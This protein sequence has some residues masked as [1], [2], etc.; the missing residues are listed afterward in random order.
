MTTTAEQCITATGLNAYRQERS[1]HD[2]IILSLPASVYAPQIGGG[3]SYVK[4]IVVLNLTVDG[5]TSLV[6]YTYSYNDYCLWL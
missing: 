3:S 2:L 6:Y 5:C 1:C 4:P